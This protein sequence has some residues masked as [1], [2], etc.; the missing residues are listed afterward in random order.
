MKSYDKGMK[1][2][3]SITLLCISLFAFSQTATSQKFHDT[4]GNIEVNKAGQL[5]Y[6]LNIDVPPGIK[7]ISPNVSLIYNSG[8][9]SGLLAY[10]WNISGLSSISRVGRNL[11]KDGI[12]K[13]VQLDYSDY[14][15]FN[16][17]RLILKSGEYGKDGAEYV[18]ENF[19]NIKIKSIGSI[20]GKAWQGPAYWEVT[21]A[22]GSQAWYGGTGTDDGS[23][24]SP[25]DYNIVKSKDS[26]GNYI[27]YNY[28]LQNNISVI[29]N[30]QWGGNE[31][32][33]TPHFNKVEFMFIPR[34]KPEIAYVKGVALYQAFTL[35]YILVSE[36]DKQYK[37]YNIS[38]KK[39][40]QQSDY[41]YI[42]KITVLNKNNVNEEANPVIFTYDKPINFD[43]GNWPVFKDQPSTISLR[44]AKDD[45]VGDFDGD[46]NLDLLR[47][48]A[49][50]SSKIAQP[51][52]YLYS[53]FYSIDYMIAS[54]QWINSSLLGLKDFNPINF[55]KSN[56]IHN[57]QG[58]VGFKKITNPST[59]K[60][61]LELSFY[62]FSGVNNL[63]LDFTKT[64]PNI[65]TYTDDPDGLDPIGSLNFTILGL[66][67]FDFNGDGLNELVLQLQYRFCSGGTADPNPPIVSK[68]NILPGQT[69]QNFKKY[70]LIDP[71][72]SLQNDSWH[73]TLELFNTNNE[74]PFK[75]YRSG[76]FNGDGVFDFLKLDQNKKPL[77][78][79]FEKNA[80]GKYVSNIASFNP[81]NNQTIS[82]AWDLGLV[83]DFN[84]DGVSDLMI[85]ETSTSA[86]WKKYT[87]TGKSFIEQSVNFFAPKPNRTITQVSASFTIYNPRTFVAYDINNDGKTELISLDSEKQYSLA[88][89]Q[90]NNQSP[91]YIRNS[92]VNARFW[93]PTGGANTV[94]SS[95]WGIEGLAENTTLY[96]NS[97]DINAELAVNSSD[98]VGLPVNH[99]TGAMLKRIVMVSAVPTSTILGESQR[100]LKL[101]YYDIAR[102]GRIT[103]ILQ[104]GVNTEIAYKQLD[105]LK[106]PG[107]YDSEKSE[108]YPYVEMEQ[109]SGMTVVSGLSQNTNS[110]KKLK[111]DFKYRGLTSNILG[112]GMIG[113][114]KQARSSWYADGFENTKV[115]SGVEIDPV[116]E[117]F[118]IKEWSIRTNN[119]S[120]IFPA[121]LSFNNT[122]LLSLKSTTY[123][124]DKLLNGQVITVP[125]TTADSP[126]V[127]TAILPDTVKAKDFLTGS[128]AENKITYGQY[129]LPAQTVSKINT[130]YAVTT[131]NYGYD[132]NPSG[133]GSDYY[134]G[135][136]TWKVE[137]VQAY[138]DTKSGKEEYT[139]ESNRIK[140]IKK[141]NSDNTG[142]LLDTYDYDAFGN[143]TQKVVSNSVDS[144][145]ET[146]AS[147]YDVKGRFI[148]KTIDNLNL[149]TSFTYNASGQVL[150]KTDPLGKSVSNVYDNWGKLTS[151]TSN[152]SGTT[153]Y[154]Y[155]RDASS[156]VTITQSSPD[157]NVV[158]KFTNKFGQEYKVS[159]KAFGQG[160]FVSQ[161]TQ[162][163]V[164]GRKTMESEPY[165]DGQSASKWNT[166][167][168]DDSIFPAKVTATAFNGKQTTTTVSG[169]TTTVKE[170]NGYGRTTSKTTDA[171][172]NVLSTTDKGGTIEF[173]Y[174]A[175]GQQTQSTYGE[176]T[177]TTKYDSWGR[178]SEF[179]DPS[180]GLYK[181]EYD[182]F[183]QA[184][185]TISPKG[186]KEYTYNNMGQLISQ[187]EFSTI[188]GGQTTN[189]NITYT[190]NDKGV[191]TIKSGTAE[192][193]AF[194]TNLAYDPNGRLSSSIE[195]SN[196]K[197]YKHK[198]IIYDNK[199]RITSYEKELQS[200]GTLTKVTIENLY[201]PWSGELYQVKDKISGKVLWE[202][203]ET[204]AKG[205]L[206]LGKLGAAEIANSYDVN[207]FLT[208]VNHSSTLKQ[209]ILQI[210][211]S[212]DAIKN[213]LKLRKTE[214]DFD[215]EEKFDYDD[216]NRLINWTNPVTG[217]KPNANRNIYD[218]KGRILENDQVG[219]MKFENST[220]I[221]QPTGMTLN[222]NGEQKYNNDL[223]QTITYNENNDPVFINGEKGD[224]AFRYGLSGMR[225]RVTYKGNFTVEG[226]GKLTKFYSEEGSFEVVKDNTTGAEK[227]IIYIGGNPYESDIVYLK[228]T[229]QSN[230]SYLFLHKDYLGSI[231]AISDEFGNKQE[232]RHFDAWG[233]LTHFKKANKFVITDRD[234]LTSIASG[235]LLIDRG[236]TG[237]EHFVE[238]GIIHMN[239][240]L[241]DPLLRRFLNADENIQDPANTQNYNKYGYVMNNP[242][243]Y[244]DPN[245]EFW[246]WVA[247]AIVGG[248]INGV[249]ANGGNLNPIKWNW[250]NSWSAVLGGA[251][252]GAAISGALGNIAGNA[253]AIKNILP[254]IISGGLN[255]A[256]T[257][258]NFLTGTVS[259]ISYT[260]NIFNN[261]I[262]S[263]NMASTGYRY[264][265]NEMEANN[266]NTLNGTEKAE[267]SIA[268]VVKVSNAHYK[269]QFIRGSWY[270]VDESSDLS[271]SIRSH[272]YSYGGNKDLLLNSNSKN[273]W[274][275][276]EVLTYNDVIVWQR[277][278]LPR[279]AFVSL[280]QLDLTMGHEIFHSILNNA[281]LF[282]DYTLSATNQRASA[283]EYYISRWEEQYVKFRGWQKLNLSMESFNTAAAYDRALEGLMKKIKP[284]FDNYLKST[285]K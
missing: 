264:S 97:S 218:V 174:N 216:N 130:S 154:L 281:R 161:D 203:K 201:S 68:E 91:K 42:D 274:G 34:E 88:A 229:A 72:E 33:S 208:N 24:R 71:D 104:G 253:G 234:Q 21:F 25:I 172:G 39:D 139:Y 129:Y 89:V 231:L 93:S 170:E 195:N 54:P 60:K 202:L 53:D 65:E 192:G 245:G 4:K 96:L 103:N 242:M 147:V 183:G 5:Q 221:Y 73:Y 59:S 185:K 273:V 142:Y 119:D 107:L 50:T 211:Y 29:N 194:S 90:D 145:T 11:E 244:S 141:W 184:K 272:G 169:L 38:Y 252:G 219:S 79:T 101:K 204:N 268:T 209:D 14:Y 276:T 227:H 143:I 67:S 18:T 226:E 225:Q 149:E 237:H 254:G 83:G 167:A 235:G 44:A 56:L 159:T 224:V 197:I 125:V 127:I 81:L 275:L 196:G 13:G 240:R 279:G 84:G 148:D 214:G 205:Q 75:M 113:F 146:T 164:L 155:E 230:G 177:V 165:F 137:V 160:Q 282:D 212:F 16:G 122:Q 28:S 152:L 255:S 210:W 162:F 112:R 82:A 243:M 144:Q 271:A 233:N 260:G 12:T 35:D 32:K 128:F 120:Q 52:V 132:H 15:S 2:I 270:I 63:V 134:I 176:N 138:S 181:Y 206:L 76:D 246:W 263:T 150:T 17:Q 108:T 215:I 8:G 62:S 175:A 188:D 85:P 266:S 20:T 58:I 277:I 153:T 163:D 135:R 189:K 36:S 267:F 239:G 182:G 123:R 26:N 198:E 57:R 269:G 66:D 259:G 151:S 158:K 236:Y 105:K 6:T 193:L 23:G 200:S 106:N 40:Y 258:S 31:V 280:E 27:N 95:F 199:G 250:Q 251:I 43:L 247:G 249:Q 166:I 118:P 248:Y 80:E 37:R 261:T 55:K 86:S 213:E 102:S 283:H 220:K 99:W 109:A 115:W 157:G 284:I 187:H 92:F 232:Q 22:D 117:G 48:H 136:P 45:V 173:T 10:N 257:G 285:L 121:D 238:V 41:R 116:H 19:S 178:K 110:D 278:Y 46:G 179:N 70:I 30:I 51:G 1:L 256:F 64:I 171:L 262:T 9:Q 7:D 87:S 3:S 191:L 100:I 124:I 61:D 186:T 131:S 156:N 49:V 78:I 111:Q 133:T 223:I 241:Y 228:N 180:N 190:Y 222:T 114:R 217:M 207:G 168:Y 94:A 98:M 69:C 47:Y 77:L 265:I 140:T 74:D 126:N